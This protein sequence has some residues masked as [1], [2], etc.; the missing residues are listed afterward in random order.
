MNKNKKSKTQNTNKN[1]FTL[2]MYI[3]LV[4]AILF[5]LFSI[6]FHA[7][8]SL[9]SFPIAAGFTAVTV[10]FGY[11]VMLRKRD[12]SKYFCV[13]KLIQYLPFVLLLAFI[14]RRVG[15]SSTAAWYDAVSVILWTVVF[16]V[17]LIIPYYLNDKRVAKAMSDWTVPPAKK[18]LIGMEKIRFE[19]VDWV[20]AFVQAVFMVL[21]IQIFIVQ[22]YV[23][24]SESMVPTFLIKDRVAVSKINCGPKFPLTDIGLPDLAGYN[25]GDIVVLRNPHYKMDRKSEVKT[26]TSQLLYMLTF[27]GVNLNRDE[28]GEPKADPLVKRVAGVSGEQLVMQDGVLYSRTK[29]NDSFTPVKADEKYACWD[30]S[31]INK[32]IYSRVERYPLSQVEFADKQHSNLGKVIASASEQYQVMLDF[33][34][35]RR[36]YDLF[37][38]EFEARQLVSRLKLLVD[39][40]NLS[41][42]FTEPQME[43]YNLFSNIQSTT[44]DIIS[45][46]GGIDWFEKFMTSWI[47]S[48]SSAKDLYAESNYKLNVMSKICFGNLVV[49]YATLLND[50]VSSSLWM[51]DTVLEE[52]IELASTLVWYIQYL[53]DSRNMPVFPANDSNGNPQY[54]PDNCYF[55]MGDNRFNSLDLRHSIDYEN[56]PL[57]SYDSYSVEYLSIMEPKYINKKLI[58]GKTMFR[59]WPID[60]PMK[61]N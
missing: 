61:I 21:I 12:G 24:P 56:A 6:S 25:R 41:G 29:D 22:L 4:S 40:E 30:L 43:V 20:D 54:I 39:E 48:K 19:L 32:K 52:N 55:M 47:D 45:K 15:K 3:E 44:V 16:I 49:R 18:K 7:D 59:F 35:K 26:V 14:L 58:I 28:N 60:R 33:E 57:S 38:A 5:S 8:A 46:K 2:F 10:Y 9:I 51:S 31:K 34:E 42:N 13:L 11:F 50:N 23:I 1:P 17:S 27:T 36:N 53:L 37:V